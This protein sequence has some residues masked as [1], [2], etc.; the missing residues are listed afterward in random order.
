MIWKP[1]NVQIRNLKAKNCASY[2][3][4]KQV[5]ESKAVLQASSLNIFF[6]PTKCLCYLVIYRPIY[7]SIHTSIHPL[8][9][10]SIHHHLSIYPPRARL[11]FYLSKCYLVVSIAIF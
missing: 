3:D 2:F 9:H 11:S 10:L 6:R 7:P 1:S 5:L 4:A 8:I